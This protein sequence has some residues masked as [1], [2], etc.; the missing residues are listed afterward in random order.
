MFMLIPYYYVPHYG[1]LYDEKYLSYNVQNILHLANDV[2]TFG[3]LDNFSCFKYKNYMQKIK[4]KLHICGKPLQKLFNRI[5]E[6][7]QL[8]IKKCH[9][10]QYPIAVYKKNKVFY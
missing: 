8:P 9:I 1:K 3:S 5:S 6:E 4:K 10:M 7:L 2:Q